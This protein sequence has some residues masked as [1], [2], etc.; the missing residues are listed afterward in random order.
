MTPLD[1]SIRAFAGIKE[2]V[3]RKL[4]ESSKAY[5]APANHLWLEFTL[6]HPA[7]LGA[8]KEGSYIV[9]DGE[10]CKIV[11][12]DKSKPGKHG[13]AK[14]RLAAV[15]IFTGSKKAYVGPSASR[16]EVPNID[17]R[18]G[19]VLSMT[20]T[21]VQIMDLENYSNFETNLIED[22]IKDKLQQGSEVEY[23]SVMGKIRIV[24]VKG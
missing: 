10:P 7:D 14:I 5:M 13:S 8:L 3:L 21:S 2:P 20:P 23:W 22:E 1:R 9:I 12:S 4:H 17:K 6:S 18:S 16:I 15:S 24:R 11:Q 19:Q